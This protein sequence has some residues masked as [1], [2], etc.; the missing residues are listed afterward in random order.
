MKPIRKSECE[1]P[2]SA[3]FF[4]RC[5]ECGREDLEYLI[6]IGEEPWFESATALVC[7]ECLG[8]ALKLI[9][10]ETKK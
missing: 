1:K 5:D 7:E 10:E 9:K 4:L 3:Y 6:E 2:G 8:K